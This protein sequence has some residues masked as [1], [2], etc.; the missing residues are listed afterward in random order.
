MLCQAIIDSHH[1][2]VPLDDPTERTD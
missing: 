1:R 2:G